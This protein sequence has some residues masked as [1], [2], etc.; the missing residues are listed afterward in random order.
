MAPSDDEELTLSDDG[1]FTA[2]RTIGGQRIGRFGGTLADGHF[3][4]L[5]AAAEAVA[6]A[7]DLTLPTPRD[8]ATETLTVGGRTLQTGSNE[9]P[10]NPWRA[11]I[12]RVRELLKA[13]VVNSPRAAVE[14]VADTRTARLVH[15]GDGPIDVDLGSVLVK[16]IRVADEGG[17]LGRWNG[18]PAG[19][20]VDNGETMV[21]TPRWVTAG[22]GWSA[23]L[24]FDHPLEL[25]PGDMFQVWVDIPIRDGEG[26]R[27]GRLYVPV[28]TDA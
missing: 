27:A 14:L 8:G 22:P 23:P 7:D 18:R 1:T 11:L 5:R 4:G 17:V 3:N 6:S 28:L 15:A 25:A 21:P 13:E 2:R 12:G 24:P 16:V 19:S 20:L 9:V 10:P 26:E